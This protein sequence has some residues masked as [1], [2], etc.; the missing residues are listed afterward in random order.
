MR[1]SAHRQVSSS[2]VK[3]EKLKKSSTTHRK[4]D[5]TRQRTGPGKQKGAKEII[6]TGSLERFVNDDQTR[7]KSIVCRHF[8]FGMW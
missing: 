3:E 6:S 2:N 7:L 1:L 8:G 4:G 5:K